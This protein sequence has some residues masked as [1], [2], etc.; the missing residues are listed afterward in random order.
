MKWFVLTPAQRQIIDPR[1][2]AYGEAIRAHHAD[3]ESF[4]VVERDDGFVGPLGDPEFY[5]SRSDEWGPH[6]SARRWI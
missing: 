4:E 2:D 5:F 1:E 3:E 6:A